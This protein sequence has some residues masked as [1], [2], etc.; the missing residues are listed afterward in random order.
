M[1]AMGTYDDA[2]TVDLTATATWASSDE[3]HA[4]VAT[5]GLVTGV[6]E[7]TAG[8]ITITAT[9]GAI[10]GTTTLTI[11]ELLA[12]AVLESIAVTPADGSV[13]M[14][15]TIQFTATGT[16]DDASTDDIT[17]DVVWTSSDETHATITAGGLASGIAESTAGEVT[18]TATLDAIEGTTTLTVGP[19]TANAS[20]V[21]T[22]EGTTCSPRVVVTNNATVTWHWSDETISTG[23]V[24]AAKNF[25]TAAHREHWMEVSVDSDLTGFGGGGDTKIGT[26]ESGLSGYVNLADITLFET[27]DLTYV[28]LGEVSH[29]TNPALSEIY[30]AYTAISEATL[31]QMLIDFAA[32]WLQNTAL[33]QTLYIRNRVTA[34]SL[35]ARESLAAYGWSINLQ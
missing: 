28:N 2:S 10:D 19:V 31:D 35:A 29:I 16:Y 6:T 15:R 7:S 22:T 12:P 18:I 13:A 17:G 9:V 33:P 11:D 8:E 27:S 24:P 32:V 20:I 4:T 25:V 21:F 5:G 1:T 23:A 34:A 26:V 30:L 3:T 14:E